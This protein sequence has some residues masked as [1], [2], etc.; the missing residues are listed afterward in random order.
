MHLSTLKHPKLRKCS[1]TQQNLKWVMLSASIFLYCLGKFLWRSNFKFLLNKTSGRAKAVQWHKNGLVTLA[2]QGNK[3]DGSGLHVF[4]IWGSR[5]PFSRPHIFF[6]GCLETVSPIHKPLPGLSSFICHN[7]SSIHWTILR[8]IWGEGAKR[9]KKKIWKSLCS[10]KHS[11]LHPRTILLSPAIGR[12]LWNPLQRV[13]SPSYSRVIQSS[14]AEL[15]AKEDQLFTAV[16]KQH[17]Y[18]S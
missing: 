5:K 18:Q 7:E 8:K 1:E 12:H 6:T 14:F 3:S 13:F 17:L 15:K 11:C 4:M 10:L 9:Q 2:T 16:L